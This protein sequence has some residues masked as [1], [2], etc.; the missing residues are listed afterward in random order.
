MKKIVFLSGTRAD[1]GKIKALV[2]EVKESKKFE[3]KIFAC[4]MHLLELYGKTFIE[5]YKDGFDEV[6]LAKPYKHH[7]KMDLALSESIKQFSAFIK[8]YKPDL[9]VVH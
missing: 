5:I 6:F 4:G 2:Q 7:E 9:S 3:Y 8:D 1:W